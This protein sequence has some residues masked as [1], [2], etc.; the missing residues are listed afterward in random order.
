MP[1]A[2]A[3]SEPASISDDLNDYDVISDNDPRSLESSIADLR[4]DSPTV[5][6][7][8]PRPPR[9]VPPSEDAKALFETARLSADDVQALVQKTVTGPGKGAVG[10]RSRSRSRSEREK[11]FRLYVDGVFDSV[12]VGT[13][14]QL[15]QAKLAFPSVH[16]LVGP[17]TDVQIRAHEMSTILPHVERCELIRHIRWVDEVLVDA[18]VVLSEDFLTRHRIDYV[19]VEEGSSVDPAISKARLAG[20]D[21]VKSIGKAIPTRRTRNVIAS[22]LSLPRESAA[23][24]PAMPP[25]RKLEPSTFTPPTPPATSNDHTSPEQETPE[26]KEEFG[27]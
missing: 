24:T 12:H 17:F 9:E 20:Y 11:S 26:P 15:R 25:S 8:A 2:Y 19:A 14:H 3:P 16:L 1:A 21:L 4:I 27:E 13:V 22:A 18:P 6:A 5:A 23:P 7:P 10:P